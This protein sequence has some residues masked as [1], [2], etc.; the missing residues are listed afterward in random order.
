MKKIAI[1][2]SGNLLSAHF[3]HCEQFYVYSV[4]NNQITNE[5]S[6]T[7]PNHQPGVYPAWLNGQGVTDVLAG[8]IGQRAIDIFKQNNINVYVGAPQIA[9]KDIVEQFTNGTLALTANFCDH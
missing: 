2:V 7:P 1:P 4:E 5:E 6:L 8:G 9:P 3:G